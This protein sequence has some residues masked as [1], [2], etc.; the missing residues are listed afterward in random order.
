MSIISIFILIRLN[1]LNILLKGIIHHQ[2]FRF[3]NNLIIPSGIDSFIREV[4]S[5]QFAVSNED[6][7]TINY[8]NDR[9]NRLTSNNLIIGSSFLFQITRKKI[10]LITSFPNLN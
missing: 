5:N 6:F 9:K 4:V 2:L 1:P 8:I 3:N 10:Y 7:N